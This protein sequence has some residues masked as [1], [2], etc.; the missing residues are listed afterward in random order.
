ME[1][2]AKI[3]AIENPAIRAQRAAHCRASFLQSADVI[4][5]ESRLALDRIARRCKDDFPDD[6]IQINIADNIGEIGLWYRLAPVSFIGHSLGPEGMPLGGQNPCEAAAF[7][8]AI[9][10]GSSVAVFSET[11]EGFQETGAAVLVRDEKEMPESILRFF[12]DAERVPFL[13]AARELIAA[14][15]TQR[16]IGRYF[17]GALVVGIQPYRD[18]PVIDQ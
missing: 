17:M 16:T 14:R 4:E 18:R 8:S 7:Q 5:P 13:H 15:G 9:T 2:S 12:V 11:K 6:R 10:H 1:E 3:H